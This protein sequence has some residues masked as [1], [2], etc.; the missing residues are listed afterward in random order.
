MLMVYA[1]GAS[2]RVVRSSE[3]LLTVELSKTDKALDLY[4]AALPSDAAFKV[5]W[6]TVDGGAEPVDKE[7]PKKFAE[8]DRNAHAS[9]YQVCGGREAAK[10]VM[11]H[12]DPSKPLGSYT[13]ELIPED[14]DGKN[15]FRAMS[16]PVR[17][18]T[19]ADVRPMQLLA[20]PSCELPSFSPVAPG[21]N[22]EDF[23]YDCADYPCGY[24]REVVEG[25]AQN[26]FSDRMLKIVEAF[27]TYPQHRGA[28][29]ASVLV[30]LGMNKD[31]NQIREKWFAPGRRDLQGWLPQFVTLREYQLAAA[32][33]KAEVAGTL[34]NMTEDLF[35]NLAKEDTLTFVKELANVVR[36]ETFGFTVPVVFNQLGTTGL[37]DLVHAAAVTAKS[38]AAVRALAAWL[39]DT[40][41]PAEANS[42][43]LL[44][45]RLP[46][47]ALQE[48]AVAVELL[49]ALA[50]STH[51]SIY[52]GNFQAMD[53]K[54]CADKLMTFLGKFKHLTTLTMEDCGLGEADN[55]P[56]GGGTCIAEMG[57]ERWREFASDLTMLKLNR[58]GITDADAPVLAKY[59]D[60]AMPRLEILDLADTKITD[61]RTISEVAAKRSPQIVVTTR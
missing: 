34:K 10:S 43:V 37:W 31:Y 42:W 35:R 33:H 22:P 14:A 24:P 44:N 50:A 49:P 53:G 45:D 11:V 2:V 26:C 9:R 5:R 41:P 27:L 59:V 60:E 52:H 25:V 39:A 4:L 19:Q 47:L 20:R 21:G 30:K 16:I 51:V 48:L 13:L 57:S 8:C 40:P 28:P 23:S 32:E 36:V 17:I 54:E 46:P 56:T 55:P 1:E 7:P 18:T 58:N 6:S 15:L 3:P 61:F 38:E 29:A 12:L